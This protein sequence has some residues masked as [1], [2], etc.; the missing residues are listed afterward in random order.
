MNLRS[1]T[2]EARGDGARGRKASGILCVD[3]VLYLLV[4]NAG[5]AQLGWSVDHGST[6]TWANWT[7]TTSFGCPTFVQFGADY[8]GAR[9]AFV[10]LVSPDSD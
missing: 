4:R 5:N 10:Y 8:A 9:D 2:G 6:W 1:A 3:G 7:W